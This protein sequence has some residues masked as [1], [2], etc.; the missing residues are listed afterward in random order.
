[1]VAG[2][3]VGVRCGDDDAAVLQEQASPRTR[4]I[5]SHLGQFDRG[6][7]L[8]RP[9]PAH[10]KV[11]ALAHPY[12]PP[13][14]TF[15]GADRL[16]RDGGAVATEDDDNLAMMRQ[17]HC[18]RIAYCLTAAPA[19]GLRHTKRRAARHDLHFAPALTDV[20]RPPQYKVYST[21]IINRGTGLGERK[22]RV[23]RLHEGGYPKYMIATLPSP[24]DSDTVSSAR[25]NGDGG[26]PSP[27]PA[28]HTGET[29]RGWRYNCEGLSITVEPSPARA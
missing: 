11:N 19:C 22:Q 28:K 23:G 29:G 1:M 18:G 27:D 20:D 9:R 25:T 21:V 5:P 6:C 15:A 24:E 2:D 26:R 7:H 14:A 3:G 13:D 4:S 17:V 10:P 8:T 12:T 16:L